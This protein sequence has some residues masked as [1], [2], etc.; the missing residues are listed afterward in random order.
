[1]SSRT[2]MLTPILSLAL[3][4]AL[5]CASG[6]PPGGVVVVRRPPPPRREVVVVSPGPGYVWVRGYYRPMRNDYDWVP[7]RWERAPSGRRHWHEPR[8]KHT[9]DGWVY[10]EG[11][12]R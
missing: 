6:P 11:Y 4:G 1:M 2:R 9:R 10:I 7:G 5:A 12:W 3:A 8:W